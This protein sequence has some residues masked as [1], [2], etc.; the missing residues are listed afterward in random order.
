MGND[1]LYRKKLCEMFPEIAYIPFVRPPYHLYITKNA[2][3]GL[4]PYIAK[5]YAHYSSLN[6]LYC[7]PNK[8][9]EYAACGLPMI[10]SDVPGLYY[11]FMQYHIG[12]TTE[13][14]SSS[15]IASILERIDE[16]YDEMVA[17]CHSFY[18]SVDMDSIVSNILQE[19]VNRES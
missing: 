4:L 12:Y 14:Q 13:N 5:R 11:P 16:N 8:I 18:N 1:T 7:A 3:V 2:H 15:E 19:S 6:A 10:G 17:N 9:F